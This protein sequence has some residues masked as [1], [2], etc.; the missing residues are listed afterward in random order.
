MINY[1]SVKK[2]IDRKYTDLNI[3]DPEKMSFMNTSPLRREVNN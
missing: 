3:L 2:D 1:D